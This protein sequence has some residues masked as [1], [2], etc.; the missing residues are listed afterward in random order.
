[1]FLI[2]FFFRLFSSFLCFESF[3]VGLCE[4]AAW[5]SARCGKDM[6]GRAGRKLRKSVWVREG[7][8]KHTGVP[9]GFV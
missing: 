3:Q 4:N 8:L 1:M 6:F 9:P 5:H 2:D 7:W